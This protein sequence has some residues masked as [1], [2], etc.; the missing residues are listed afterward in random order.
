MQLTINPE[1]E[2]LV[3]LLSEVEFDNLRESIKEK[4]LWVPIIINNKKIILDG[5]HRHKICV[6]LGVKINTIERNFDTK[7]DE[8]IFVLEC[9]AKRR[10]LDDIG[11]HK[12]YENLKPRYEE[13]S[14]LSQS[15]A[16]GDHTSEK[17]KERLGSYDPKR[18][19]KEKE[20]NK[21][22]TQAAKKV[23]LSRVKAEKM[24]YVKEHDP[25]LYDQIGKTDRMTVNKAYTTCRKNEKR[26]ERQK[27]VQKIQV[28]LP[29][30]V[31]LHNQEFQT[32]EIPENSISLIFTDP[33]YGEE[34]LHLI[35]DLMFH[36]VKVLKNNGSLI[37]YP[38]HAHIDKVFQY[39]KEAGLTYH[40]IIAVTHSG[41]SSSIFGRKVLAA[42]K[43]MLWFT[44]G[45]YEGEFVKDLIKSEFQGKELHE[46]AQSTK[47][48]DYYIKYTTI[49][50]EIVY[51]PFLGQGTFGISAVKLKRQFIGCEVN[52]KHYE[53]AK[54]LISNSVI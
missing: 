20:D 12:I 42:Y 53:T 39:A 14:K 48:S 4:G 33:P 8:E 21:S 15:K 26:K 10:Q 9:N 11:K 32:A 3:P 40:W 28:N 19:S 23:N 38:G 24:N 52:P 54:R 5:H 17:S 51:D 22:S 44:K 41:P 25:E 50:N 47:E 49:E 1:Y 46:W 43:P 18:S 45:K 7:L 36:A 35:K 2:K 30:T 34:S 37:F 31:T 6:D 27:A 29:E 13:E 16:G